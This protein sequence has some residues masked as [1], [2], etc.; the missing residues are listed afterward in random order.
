MNQI[1]FMEHLISEICDYSR[2]NDMEPDDTMKAIAE[3]LLALLKI[4]TFNHW[5][6]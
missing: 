2:E 4:S 1:E 5:G 3:N 6:E